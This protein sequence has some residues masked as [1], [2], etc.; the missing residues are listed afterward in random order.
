MVSG[1]FFVSAGVLSVACEGRGVTLYYGMR[2]REWVAIAFSESED[3]TWT[4]CMD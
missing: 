2:G 4:S 1:P 3:G